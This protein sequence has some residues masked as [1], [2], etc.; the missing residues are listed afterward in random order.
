MGC[1]GRRLLI[2]LIEPNRERE[3]RVALWHL[4]VCG[5]GDFE[6]FDDGHKSFFDQYAGKRIS[7]QRLLCGRCGS[8]LWLEQVAGRAE[9]QQAGCG[10]IYIATTVNGR[11]YVVLVDGK[12]V[13]GPF[14]T[15]AEAVKAREKLIKGGAADA[16]DAP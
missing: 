12:V 16:Q 14:A 4:C 9:Q 7:K 15:A 3:L 1:G 6:L 2:L 10:M 11:E 5:D 8:A 13:A